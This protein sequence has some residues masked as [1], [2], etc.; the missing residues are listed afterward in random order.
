M[1]GRIALACTVFLA[2]SH[3]AA[4]QPS[5][6]ARACDVAV[7]AADMH[8]PPGLPLETGSHAFSYDA[9]GPFVTGG[10]GS[11]T[12]DVAVRFTPGPDAVIRISAVDENCSGETSAGTVFSYTFTALQPHRSEDAAKRGRGILPRRLDR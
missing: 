3:L 12:V 10:S 5:L 6:P 7:A 8:Y 1:T 4:A 9:G 11:I 2:A